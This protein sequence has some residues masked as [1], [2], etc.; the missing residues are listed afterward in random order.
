MGSCGELSYQG[1]CDSHTAR[2][3]NNGAIETRDCASWGETCGWVG[4]DKGFYC[5]D[6]PTPPPAACGELSYQGACDGDTAHW[7]DNEG[8]IQTR[9]CSQFDRICG[10]AGA[11]K[12]YYCISP[13]SPPPA[14]CGD[15]TYHGECDGYTARWCDDSEGIQTRECTQFGQTCGWASEEKGYYCINPTCDDE[16]DYKG[17]CNGAVAEWCSGGMMEIKDCAAQGQACG[18]TNDDSGFYCQ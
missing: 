13:P 3:C 7:C 4:N 17:R 8:T 9:D 2:W 11:D 12:G 15:L 18:W 5:V 1:E 10:W 14:E 6:Q 16:L